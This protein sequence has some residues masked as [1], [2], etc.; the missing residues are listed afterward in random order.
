MSVI[1]VPCDITK[2]LFLLV[3]DVDPPVCILSDC[4]NC[5]AKT[6]R[7]RSNA[8][9]Q[10]LLYRKKRVPISSPS[11]G[12][13][14]VPT[15][16][17]HTRAE[18]GL[19]LQLRT[20]ASSARDDLSELFTAGLRACGFSWTCVYVAFLPSRSSLRLPDWKRGLSV[21][22]G[23]IWFRFYSAWNTRGA[24]SRSVRA[25]WRVGRHCEDVRH[26][27]SN[28]QVVSFGSVCRCRK[29]RVSH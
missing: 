11:C 25:R 15:V 22:V 2:G 20:A 17:S 12:Q 5:R 27:P 21:A 24:C 10:A 16:C 13:I 26:S 28:A 7:P 4:I 18:R 29:R 6:G 19:L 3:W 9:A 23:G 1:C 8:V 14:H